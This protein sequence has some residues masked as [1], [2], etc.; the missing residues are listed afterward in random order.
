MNGMI[1]AKILRITRMKIKIKIAR[2]ITPGKEMMAMKGHVRNTDAPTEMEED[3]L[4][5]EQEIEVIADLGFQ[6]DGQVPIK[7]YCLP[8][9]TRKCHI[10]TSIHMFQKHCTD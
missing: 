5:S 3:L 8:Q 10:M 1:V 4:E 9:F 6:T 7:Q 2:V